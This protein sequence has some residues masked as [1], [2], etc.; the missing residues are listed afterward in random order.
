M[1]L[2]LILYKS[3]E[4][5]LFFYKATTAIIDRNAGRLRQRLWPGGRASGQSA[6]KEA[7]GRAIPSAVAQR[8]RLQIVRGV[9]SW[10]TSCTRGIFL[11]FH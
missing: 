4:L 2:A 9:F 7:A 11:Q 8:K 5:A 6:G 10:P 3:M 1:E